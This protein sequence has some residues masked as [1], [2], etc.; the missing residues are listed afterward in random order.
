MAFVLDLGRLLTVRDYTHPV[1]EPGNGRAAGNIAAAANAAD[2]LLSW[3]EG[4]VE[5]TADQVVPT[6]ESVELLSEAALGSK[7]LS[8]WNGPSIN[9]A[10]MVHC[11]PLP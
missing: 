4:L 7:E 10:S 2:V 1:F 3:L 9:W 5:R 6:T 8:G 11:C